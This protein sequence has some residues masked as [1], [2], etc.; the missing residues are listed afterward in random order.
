MRRTEVKRGE[1]LSQES[2]RLETG[3]TL[4]GSLAGLLE[5]A[6]PLWGT[7]GL[8]QGKSSAGPEVQATHKLTSGQPTSKCT[9]TGP[10]PS[11]I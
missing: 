4:Q 9:G 2:A 10:L 6:A 5:M 11:Q 1:A 7:E 3:L 8:A